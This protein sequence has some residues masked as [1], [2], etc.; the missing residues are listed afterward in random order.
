MSLNLL[1]DPNSTGEVFISTHD[2]IEGKIV[3]TTLLSSSHPFHEFWKT[4]LAALQR[5]GLY[6]TV[7]DAL[8][9]LTQRDASWRR[10]RSADAIVGMRRE[11]RELFRQHPPSIVVVSGLGNAYGFHL[12]DPLFWPFIHVSEE[13]INLWIDADKSSEKGLALTVLITAAIDHAIGHWMFTLVSSNFH[14]YLM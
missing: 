7:I 5:P 13:Y 14:I 3:P 10:R 2:A 8:V 1:L 9:A 11:M 4:H 12:R 6:D